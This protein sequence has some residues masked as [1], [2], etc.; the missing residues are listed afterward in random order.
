MTPTL[1]RIACA[2]IGLCL[3]CCGESDDIKSVAE[4]YI[5]STYGV[6]NIES[7]EVGEGDAQNVYVEARFMDAK[8]KMFKITLLM[9]KDHKWSVSKELRLSRASAP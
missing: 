2:A 3:C 5:Y 6:S 4:K 1:N 7:I 8:R 9:V